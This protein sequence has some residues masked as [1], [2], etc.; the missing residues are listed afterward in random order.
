M[1][2][3]YCEEFDRVA[4][5]AVNDHIW[6]SWNY[7]FAGTMNATFSSYQWLHLEETHG[8]QN[9]TGNER[10]V[11]FGLRRDVTS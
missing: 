7:Q 11:L 8:I 4:A 10:G 3:E 1:A 9:P 5:N 2:A 6:R